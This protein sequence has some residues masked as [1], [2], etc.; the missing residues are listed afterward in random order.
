MSV[1]VK[2]LVKQ[3]REASYKLANLTTSAKNKALK[4]M[5]KVLMD[6]RDFI[7]KENKIHTLGRYGNWEYSSMEKSLRDAFEIIEKFKC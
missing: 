7:L 6:S 1:Y 5:A 4:S 3:A 2:G